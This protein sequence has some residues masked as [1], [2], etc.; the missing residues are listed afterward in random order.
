[1]RLRWAIVWAS[2]DPVTGR[3]QSGLRPALVVSNEGFNKSSG[4][5]TVLPLTTAR[6][7]PRSWELL[8]SAQATGLQSDSLALPQQI[9]TISRERVQ[10]IAGRLLEPAL[11]KQIAACIT[12]HLGLQ[13]ADL[14]D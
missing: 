2:L 13:D 8:L 9:R 3:E 7:D 11:R 12:L 6:R 10:R 1:M 14:E 5:L 4:L